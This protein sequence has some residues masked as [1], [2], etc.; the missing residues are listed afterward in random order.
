MFLCLLY[1][2]Q[3]CVEL[4]VRRNENLVH[5]YSLEQRDPIHN[6]DTSQCQPGIQLPKQSE[7]SAKTQGKLATTADKLKSSMPQQTRSGQR[8]NKP[9]RYED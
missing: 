2:G 3:L 7:K 5:N 6:R 4:T 1:G 9:K 8:V